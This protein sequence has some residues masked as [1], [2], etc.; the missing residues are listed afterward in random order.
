MFDSEPPPTNPSQPPPTDESIRPMSYFGAALWVTGIH[1]AF[2][3]VVAAVISL[4]ESASRDLVAQLVCQI[5]AYSLGLFFMLRVHGPQTPIRQ[6][7]AI[8]STSPLL[9]GL[10]TLLG[11]AVA[12][13][14][15]ALLGAIEKRWPS[16]ESAS[17]FVDL[18]FQVGRAEQWLIAAGVVLI[19]PF[20]EE[21]VFRG[22]LFTPLRRDKPAAQVI[23]LTA[24]YFALVH[25]DPR[26]MVP[27]FFLGLL[28]GYLRH[29]SG[30]LLPALAMHVGFNA[31]P[32]IDLLGS[33]D[34]APASDEVIDLPV[35]WL[36]GS[37]VACAILI[38]AIQLIA[39]HSP[40]AQAARS[41]DAE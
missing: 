15:A 24:A 2:L 30:S 18:F 19:G 3:W 26:R 27:I 40:H 12:I 32:F 13:P 1:M 25:L 11:G 39:Q 22:G 6:F 29:A 7:V 23:F 41:E 37:L 31:I 36:A 8:R 28:L 10:A 14:A 35:E 33:R 9:V 4:R 21:V 38:V 16:E 20:V 5:V 17:D 34:G